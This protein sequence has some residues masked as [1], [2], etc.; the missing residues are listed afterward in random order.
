VSLFSSAAD[1]N[2][3]IL[4][5]LYQI[6]PDDP[7]EVEEWLEQFLN[8]G[9]LVKWITTFLQFTKCQFTICAFSEA[10]RKKFRDIVID[11]HHLTRRILDFLAD[12]NDVRFEDIRTL[13]MLHAKCSYYS[14][15][16]HTG[17]SRLEYVEKPEI[18]FYELDSLARTFGLL[19][20]HGVIQGMPTNHLP[21]RA[22]RCDCCGSAYVV[23][24]ERDNQYCSSRC[25]ARVRTRRN[26]AKKACSR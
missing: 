9:D 22:R 24:R 3:P 26:R 13:G 1:K 5:T 21:L 14:Y 17:A 2:L 15:L 6:D 19:Q 12:Q 18:V 11:Y 8:R 23:Q 7:D 16:Y 4:T 25:R 20:K 10:M